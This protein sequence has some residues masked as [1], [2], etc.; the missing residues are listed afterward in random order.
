MPKHT[1]KRYYPFCL[2]IAFH[3][4]PVCRSKSPTSGT[5]QAMFRYPR[6]IWLLRYSGAG[7]GNPLSFG[8]VE[9]LGRSAV[10]MSKACAQRRQRPCPSAGFTNGRL[11]PVPL[12]RTTGAFGDFLHPTYGSGRIAHS[13]ILHAGCLRHHGD[14]GRGNAGRNAA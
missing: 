8:P 13:G 10:V 2:K 7:R 9:F 14:K 6:V 1:R 4:H 5:C 3:S 12:T 11:S